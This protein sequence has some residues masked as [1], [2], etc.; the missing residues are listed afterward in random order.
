M[1]ELVPKKTPAGGGVRRIL[2]GAEDDVTT[3]GIGTS[4]DETCAGCGAAIGVDADLAEVV[5]EARLKV[6]ELVFGHL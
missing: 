1:G 4:L 3:C 2:P 5:A 6:G